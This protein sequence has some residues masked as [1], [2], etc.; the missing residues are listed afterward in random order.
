MKTRG[1]IP[2]FIITFQIINLINN[3]VFN[4]SSKRIQVY[5]NLREKLKTQ[6]QNN[7]NNT[8]HLIMSQHHHKKTNPG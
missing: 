1:S 4:Y 3:F 7:N 2:T 5:N 6:R 8:D